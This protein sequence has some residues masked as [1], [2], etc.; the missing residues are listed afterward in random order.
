MLIRQH[1]HQLLECAEIIL[2]SLPFPPLA[3]SWTLTALRSVS[4]DSLNT[5]SWSL[6]VT[7]S[8]KSHVFI[9][10]PEICTFFTKRTLLNSFCW[11]FSS[12]ANV[13]C[14]VTGRFP[15]VLNG[16]ENSVDASA[17]G[18]GIARSEIHSVHSWNRKSNLFSKR[19]TCSVLFSPPVYF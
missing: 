15:F 18:I 11:P 6:T 2:R 10:A 9:N 8:W 4:A 3:S 13:D 14:T 12:I 7:S 19:T 5:T 1:F 17:K 16:T